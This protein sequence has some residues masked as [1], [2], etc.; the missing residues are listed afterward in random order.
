MS[1]CL[2]YMSKTKNPLNMIKRLDIAEVKISEFEE[3]GIEPTKIKHSTEQNGLKY[4]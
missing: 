2:N 1:K 3:I 4:Q